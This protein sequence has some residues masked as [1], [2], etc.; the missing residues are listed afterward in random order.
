M[1]EGNTQSFE[2]KKYVYNGS[3]STS[4]EVNSEQLSFDGQ[5]DIKEFVYL[6]YTLTFYNAYNNEVGNYNI[7]DIYSYNGN[8][9]AIDKVQ[10]NGTDIQDGERY[11]VPE[12]GGRFDVYYAG[13]IENGEGSDSGTTITLSKNNISLTVG[14]TEYISASTDSSQSITWNSNDSAI[15]TVSNAGNSATVTA[16]SA[17]TTTITASIGSVTASCTVTVSAPSEYTLNIYNESNDEIME[18]ITIPNGE[19]INAFIYDTGVYNEVNKKPGYYISE[20]KNRNTDDIIQD[21]Q[22]MKGD[23]NIYPG[24]TEIKTKY[25]CA[26]KLPD[27]TQ[28]FP[29][30]AGSNYSLGDTGGEEKHKLT[31]AEMPSHSHSLNY[32]DS[33]GSSEDKYYTGREL[34]PTNKIGRID[35]CVSDAHYMM[36]VSGVKNEFGN[37]IGNIVTDTGADG[38]H[39]NMP[40]YLVVNFI[41]KYK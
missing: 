38:Y 34:D 8:F 31:I 5:N 14:G 39:N 26:V 30:C 7:D 15:A 13:D 32:I 36:G 1:A 35:T 10:W 6:P 33:N 22:T 40:P 11:S 3:Q 2:I 23:L 20:W 21:T 16:V 37:F 9:L 17:G 41:I 28:R 18:T 24:Y 27:L 29:F 25:Y 4:I 12:W 19:Q